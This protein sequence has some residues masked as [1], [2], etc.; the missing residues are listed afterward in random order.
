[1]NYYNCIGTTLIASS[2][3]FAQNT[4][5]LFTTVVIKITSD[6]SNYQIGHDGGVDIEAAI[7]RVGEEQTLSIPTATEDVALEVRTTSDY[8]KTQVLAAHCSSL[9]TIS[10]S[11]AA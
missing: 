10:P 11:H 3:I 5:I 9:L 7:H 1:M 4:H 2:S 6:Y 8:T